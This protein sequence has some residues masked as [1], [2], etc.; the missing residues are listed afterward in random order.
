MKNKIVDWIITTTNWENKIYFLNH[1]LNHQKRDQ[2]ANLAMFAL[3]VVLSLTFGIAIG[4]TS[5]VPIAGA[6]AI[7]CL[8]PAFF[9]IF[10][11]LV[12]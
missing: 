7:C 10:V 11:F 5:D 1:H 8:F 12:K 9:M 3:F 4:I 6:I 2:Q